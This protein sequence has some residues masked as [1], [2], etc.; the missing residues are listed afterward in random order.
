MDVAIVGGGFCGTILATRLAR[1]DP[2]L[3]IALIDGSG[4]FATGPAYGTCRREH[5]LN[6]PAGKMSAY[7]ELPNNFVEWLRLNRHAISDLWAHDPLHTDYLPRA[8]YGRYLTAQLNDAVTECHGLVK[9]SQKV[10]DLA[11]ARR[12]FAVVLAD[13]SRLHP[14][15]CVIATG[16][17]PPA[18]IAQATREPSSRYIANPWDLTVPERLAQSRNIVLIGS[19]LTA[20]DIALTTQAIN[21]HARIRM[22]SRHGR[23]PRQHQDPTPRHAAPLNLVELLGA[24]SLRHLV[25]AVRAQIAAAQTLGNSWHA[26]IDA[27][28]PLMPAI[29]Q[30]LSIADRRRFLRHVRPLW[31]IHR[32][33]IAPA[34]ARQL[35]SFIERGTLEV[36]RGRVQAIESVRAD[37]II[38]CTGPQSDYARSR[39]V[40]W[41]NLLAR[42]LAV[43]DDLGLG[44]VTDED[45]LVTD[46]SGNAVPGLYAIGSA[47]RPTFYESTA[48]PELRCQVRELA[49]QLSQATTRAEVAV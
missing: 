45:G 33:R 31:E 19:G 47:L 28:R 34:V 40:L 23:L 39:D 5:L 42:G 25:V 30:D 36:H 27:I 21:P 44:I 4:R 3:R 32:H 26:V 38:N 46:A 20:I 14:G 15:Q 7:P 1:W 35:H 41:R 10:V 6:V 48:V 11:R 12:G 2:R 13:G 43:A 29:W 17:L 37:L 22:I 18:D 49:A 16:N 8:L 9:V 24:P